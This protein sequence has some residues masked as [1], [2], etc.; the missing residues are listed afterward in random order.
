MIKESNIAFDQ[1]FRY[2]FND[3]NLI[4]NDLKKKNIDSLIDWCLKYKS[5]LDDMKST[6]HFE[7]IKL[8]VSIALTSQFILLFKT[9]PSSECVEY[10][11]KFFQ[12]FI[13]EQKYFEQISKIMTL[14]IFKG[15]MEN[16]PYTEF[17]EDYLW[18]KITN[19]FISNCC[20]I[21][22]KFFHNSRFTF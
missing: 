4:T 22:S 13:S 9:Q 5:L 14:L 7:A 1:N 21:L 2:I 17:N 15:N 11:K 3:L 20:T 18:T 10:S 8:K 19:M 12:G 6:I 16:C